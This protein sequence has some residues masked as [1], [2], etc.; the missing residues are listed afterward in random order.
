MSTY[1]MA[2]NDVAHPEE[3]N[4]LLPQEEKKPTQDIRL[5]ISKRI[6][7]VLAVSMASFAFV[8]ALRGINFVQESSF[9][10]QA[11]LI[12]TKTTDSSPV[13]HF[14]YD[15]VQNSYGTCNIYCDKVLLVEGSNC[16]PCNNRDRCIEASLGRDAKSSSE[17]QSACTSSSE[18]KSYEWSDRYRDICY[19]FSSSAPSVRKA[20]NVVCYGNDNGNLLFIGNGFCKTPTGSSGADGSINSDL[21]RCRKDYF[22]SNRPQGPYKYMLFYPE[23]MGCRVFGILGDGPLPEGVHNHPV[24]MNKVQECQ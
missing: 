11:A 3:G 16:N 15:L 22:T 2:P 4:S 21:E 1:Q 19:L 6:F 10:T 8:Y 7:I 14:R 9:A 17:C 5:V 13:C 12:A 23:D 24:C 20:A 18:C